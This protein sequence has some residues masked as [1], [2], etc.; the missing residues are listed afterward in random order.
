MVAAH[1]SMESMWQNRESLLK[2]IHEHYDRNT[3]VTGKTEVQN[4]LQPRL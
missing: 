2:T 4:D 1:Q 3:R